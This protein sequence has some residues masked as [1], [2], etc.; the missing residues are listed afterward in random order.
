RPGE[1]ARAPN[2]VADLRKAM[3]NQDQNARLNAAAG[4]GRL[5]QD[6][7]GAVREL[8]GLLRDGQPTVR[9][10]AAEALGQIGPPARPAYPALREAAQ[11]DARETVRKSAADAMKKV[12]QPTPRDLELALGLLK[13]DDGD[14]RSAAIQVLRLIGPEARV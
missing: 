3:K 2:P 13:D 5:A 11:G 12:S 14:I 8:V 1:G 9:A 6:L 10:A 4:V 7:T